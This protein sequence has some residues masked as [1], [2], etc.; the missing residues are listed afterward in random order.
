MKSK[1]P[2]PKSLHPTPPHAKR[3]FKGII[4]DVYQWE[5]E[6]FDGTKE[7]FEKLKRADSVGVIPVTPDGKIIVTA[8]EQPGREQFLSIPGGRIDE[9]ETSLEAAAREL[10]EETGYEAE[11]FVLLAAEQPS[12][13]IDWAVYVFIGINCRKVG[14]CE[15]DAGERITPRA[16]TFDEFFALIRENKIR[17][18]SLSQLTKETLRA[19]MR[20]DKLE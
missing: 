11:K 2:R 7:I 5:Q 15:L 3:V 4:F 9:G 12:S 6:M 16:V 20:T 1:L 10:R 8:E 14:D 13:K 18:W 19:K 17:E